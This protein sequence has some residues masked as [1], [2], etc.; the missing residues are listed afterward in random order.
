[1]NEY[2]FFS[3]CFK[4]ALGSSDVSGYGTESSGS[5]GSGGLHAADARRG[6]KIVL[7]SSA[8]RNR[9]D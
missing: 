7:M 1:M 6:T 8:D 3:F 9:C 2:L 5:N 4:K